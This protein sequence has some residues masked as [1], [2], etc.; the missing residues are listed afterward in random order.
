MKSQLSLQLRFGEALLQEVYLSIKHD[1]TP[2]SNNYPSF[3]HLHTRVCQFQISV[4]HILVC[5]LL[6]SMA[7]G[8]I[9]AG[10]CWATSNRATITQSW[11][12][13]NFIVNSFHISN[14]ISHWQITA[15]LWKVLE[16]KVSRC[17]RI[18][19][20]IIWYSL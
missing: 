17:P 11:Q 5:R 2:C 7:A 6:V 14:T 16:Q 19:N 1:Y 10:R 15:L 4:C 20:F 18:H 8:L 3:L 12:N 13:T 9:C